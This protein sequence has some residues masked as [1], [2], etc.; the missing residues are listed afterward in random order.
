MGKLTATA[1]KNAKATGKAYKLTDGEGLYLAVNAKG[2]RSWRYNY[3]L[4]GRQLT[5]TYGTYPA[6]SLSKARDKHR[7]A[8]K[9]VS[10]GIDP[11]EVKKAEKLSRHLNNANSF[12]AVATEW[13]QVKIV[14]GEKSKSYKDRTWRILTKDLFPPLGR[15]PVGDITPPQLLAAVQKIIDD[16]GALDIAHRAKQAA[17]LVFR[18]AIVT[19]RADRNPANDI[20]GALPP[21]HKKHHAAIIDPLEAGRLLVVIDGFKGSPVVSTA[22]RLSPLLFQRPAEIR[23]M[24]WVEINW[25][26]SRWE[27]PAEKMKM[28]QPHVVPL[29]KQAIALLEEIQPLTGRG[30][31]VLPNARGASRCMSENGVRTALRTLG[32]DNKVMTPHGFRA[33]ARTLL[34]EVLG[35]RVEHI[36]HQL[37]HAVKDAN[38]TA[39]NRTKFLPQRA[40]MMQKWA[41]YL[42]SLKAQ[43]IAGNVIT[44]DF[45]QAK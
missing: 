39:Y 25:E 19:G 38:G 11:S 33:M 26:E 24:E 21:R 1:V 36:E 20:T 31:Y 8:H 28:R 16:R 14:G 3:R 35:E 29:S 37:A 4:N 40:A 43:T 9:Q 30:R 44:G 15:V 45:K 13:F 17:G 6:L 2:G 5:L 42:D 10:E 18:Y 22:L 34:D 32:Y 41:D 23:S 27:I 12:E 7:E